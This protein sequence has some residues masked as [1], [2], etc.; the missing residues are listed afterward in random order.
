MKTPKDCSLFEKC[1]APLCPLDPGLKARAWLIEEQVCRKYHTR[2]IRKQ[3]SIQKRQTASYQGRL[4]SILDLISVS[5]PKHFSEKQLQA[6]RDRLKNARALR[7][8]PISL[9]V[10]GGMGVEPI[11]NPNPDGQGGQNG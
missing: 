1:P 4:I 7:Q 2:W 8:K 3:K 9:Q 10:S 5:R 6:I 11:P